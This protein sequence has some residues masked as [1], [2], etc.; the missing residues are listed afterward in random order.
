[1]QLQP[2]NTASVQLRYPLGLSG[3]T[4]LLEAIDGGGI[5][6]NNVVIDA[7]RTA[8]LQFQVPT[9]AGVYR[10]MVNASGQLTLLQFEVPGQ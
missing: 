2:G 5:S 1:M 10:L 3:T 6:G 9:D 4:L 8:F 7:D